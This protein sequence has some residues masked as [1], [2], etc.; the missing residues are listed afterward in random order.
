[1][2]CPLLLLFAFLLRWPHL[3]SIIVLATLAL[4]PC[5]VYLGP[6]LFPVSAL[7]IIFCHAYQ[8]GKHT[9]TFF[10]FIVSC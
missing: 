8:L 9:S 1:V 7:K 3:P 2:L 4:T 5:L 6:H 10:E